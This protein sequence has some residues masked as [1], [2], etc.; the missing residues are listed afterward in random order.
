MIARALVDDPDQV[1]VNV[2]EGSSCVVLE[3]SMSNGDW[4]RESASKEEPL[5]QSVIFS[6]RLVAGSGRE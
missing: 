2:I 5:T 1:K 3:L 6:T 4:G